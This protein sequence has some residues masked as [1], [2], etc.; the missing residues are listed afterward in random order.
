MGLMIAKLVF[1]LSL[2]IVTTAAGVVIL[3]SPDSYI[4]LLLALR[5][6]GHPPQRVRSRYEQPGPRGIVVYSAAVAVLF[7]AGAA[8]FG[9]VVL[10]TRP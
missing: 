5:Y 2:A 8:W 7:I 4:R 9:T 1:G 3:R 10:L 6:F